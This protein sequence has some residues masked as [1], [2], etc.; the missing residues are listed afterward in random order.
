MAQ[1]SRDP[2]TAFTIGFN[3]SS[4]DETE[5]ARLVAERYHAHHVVER[6]DGSESDLVEKLPDIFDEPFGDSSALP[7][8]RLMQ[9]ARR[10]VTVALSGDGGDECFGGYR[11]FSWHS[12]LHPVRRFPGVHTAT[13]FLLRGWDLKIPSGFWRHVSHWSVPA[14][15]SQKP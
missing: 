6:M 5:Y 2:I 13:D 4:H 14:R 11:Q 10:N 3:D 1:A 8:F 7:A 12:R 15:D 9:L